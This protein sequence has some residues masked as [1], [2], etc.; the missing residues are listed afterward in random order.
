M[1]LLCLRFIVFSLDSLADV[2]IVAQGVLVLWLQLQ[3]L[4]DLLEALSKIILF[5]FC[6]TM[7][8][9]AQPLAMLIFAFLVSKFLAKSRCSIAL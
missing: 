5:I 7:L 4:F 1:S 8:A 6:S 9:K 3:G 2:I